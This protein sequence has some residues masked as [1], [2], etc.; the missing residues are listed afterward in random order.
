MFCEYPP[1]LL[2]S[3][4]GA[5]VFLFLLLSFIISCEPLRGNRSQEKRFT[6]LGWVWVWV[7]T[8]R[9]TLG[10]IDLSFRFL[11][12]FGLF[13]LVWDWENTGTIGVGF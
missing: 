4:G 7:G 8:K 12:F 13:S 11:S 5:P 3:S 9:R 6:E 2:S 10:V 1:L